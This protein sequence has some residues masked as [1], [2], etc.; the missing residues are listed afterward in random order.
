MLYAVDATQ[1]T[2]IKGKG[3]RL[4]DL[5]VFREVNRERA[6]PRSLWFQR[7]TRHHRDPSV[8]LVKVSPFGE[9]E[10]KFRG[11]LVALQVLHY[12]NKCPQEPGWGKM[13]CY[14]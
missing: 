10:S 8:L 13:V 6:G 11:R 1:S 5:T 3:D 7:R 4:L 14:R 12:L 2:E 9:V